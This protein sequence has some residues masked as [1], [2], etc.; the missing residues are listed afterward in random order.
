MKFSNIFI[1]LIAIL[2]WFSCGSF[3]PNSNIEIVDFPEANESNLS[4][5]DYIY[6]SLKIM[7]PNVGNY[8]LENELDGH[9]AEFFMGGSSF[10]I[11]FDSGG[12]WVK[13]KVK[14]RF[15]KSINKNVIEAIKNSEFEDW[16]IIKKELSEKPGSLV[17]EFKFQKDQEVYEVKYDSSGKLVKKEKSSFQL[18]K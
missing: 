5:I 12:N 7:Y 16:K 6:Q 2:F 9:K 11:T 4:T 10:K 17:Y 1:F 8:T 15:T 14:I 13:S 3:N 18:I